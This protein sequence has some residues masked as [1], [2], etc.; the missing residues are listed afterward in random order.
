[1]GNLRRLPGKPQRTDTQCKENVQEASEAAVEVYCQHRHMCRRVP[2]T[3]NWR[4]RQR[5]SHNWS[6]CQSGILDLS[7]YCGR[8]SRPCRMLSDSLSFLFRN[9]PSGH[10]HKGDRWVLSLAHSTKA[11]WAGMISSTRRLRCQAH[12]TD[13]ANFQRAVL[14]VC[15]RPANTTEKSAHSTP[16]LI[17][18]TVGAR[19]ESRDERRGDLCLVVFGQVRL[20]FAVD[21]GVAPGIR[22]LC[23]RVER[24]PDPSLSW[25]HRYRWVAC[26]ATLGERAPIDSRRVHSLCKRNFLCEASAHEKQ[27]VKS[28]IKKSLS[29]SQATAAVGLT[30][31]ADTCR[32]A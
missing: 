1:M 31:H 27:H 26:D 22:C 9:G 32:T 20:R 30:L 5:P 29:R 4:T 8:A 13:M 25:K 19:L 24:E 23:R 15:C 16:P 11:L 3:L 18:V 2:C 17:C 21:L 7:T 12:V 6:G 14:L 10:L 28:R